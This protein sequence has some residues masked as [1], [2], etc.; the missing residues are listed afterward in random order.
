[1]SHGRVTDALVA[2]VRRQVDEH[3]LV[4]WLDPERQYG[5]IPPLLGLEGVPVQVYDISV[6]ELRRRIDSMLAGWERPQLVVYV[7]FSEARVAGPL[8]ELV[9]AATVLKPGQQPPTRNTRLAVVARSA[10]ADHVPA[11]ILES[12]TRQV[13]AGQLTLDDLDQLGEQAAGAGVG[14]LGL[15]FG[16][17]NAADIVLQFLASGERDATLIAK[18]AFGE[19]CSLLSAEYGFRIGAL[20]SPEELRQGLARFLLGTELI[21]ALGENLP[22]SLH[23]IA[24]AEPAHV[25]K[26]ALDLLRTWR[27]RRDLQGSYVERAATVECELNLG[28]LDLALD[29]AVR[30]EG[31]RVLDE[32]LQSAV[33]D[34][35]K[36][37]AQQSLVELAEQ[38]L[39]GFWASVAP[40]VM[41]RWALIAAIGRVLLQAD[42]VEAEVKVAPPDAR[43][44]AA[45][46]VESAATAAEPW[47]FLDASHRHMERQYH[48]FELDVTGTHKRLE[49]L[50]AVARRRYTAAATALSEKF[51][52]GLQISG[53]RID[54]LPRQVETFRRF[55]QP[56]LDAGKVAYVL[57]DG[58]RYEMARELHVNLDP[59]HE[60]ELAATLGTLPSI[61]E[62]G[63]AALL[64]RA[65]EGARLASASAHLC[66]GTGRSV[67]ITWPPRPALACTQL[68]SRHCYRPTRRCAR[69]SR[70]QTWSP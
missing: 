55:V 20:S 58:L 36:T 16:T 19:L 59:E 34:G 53:F 51:V 14:T 57:V 38:R 54:G 44:L 49:Q 12:I 65:H 9:A 24:R 41:Q 11:A 10:L 23:D 46:Y 26:K 1:M 4:L 15:V 70:R 6:F 43:E 33:E 50:V 27:H 39:T 3:G 67:S 2:R 64:P 22:K 42:R 56:A 32:K 60:A 25:A 29:V 31:F 63:M 48:H 69:P 40:E 21:S 18:E 37:N 35:L 8:A 7:P 62:V 45:R 13:E 66:S 5:R 47:S 68:G 28:S 17:S 52:R 30:L 61:T